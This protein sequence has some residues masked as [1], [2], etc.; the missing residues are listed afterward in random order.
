MARAPRRSDRRVRG[1][2]PAQPRLAQ[3]EGLEE[4]AVVGSLLSGQPAAVL[5]PALGAG[6]LGL[7]SL[8]AGLTAPPDGGT[9]QP[10]ASSAFTVTAP[11]PTTPLALSP[12]RET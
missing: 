4:R 9:G 5:L 7:D 6:L 12:A 1:G 3:L 8:L 11:G 10:V 2:R